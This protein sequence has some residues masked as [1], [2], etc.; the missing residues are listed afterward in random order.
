MKTIPIKTPK[1]KITILK[2]KLNT[3]PTEDCMV[4]KNEEKTNCEFFSYGQYFIVDRY[5][6]LAPEKF[7]HLAWRNIREDIKTVLGSDGRQ[8]SPTIVSKCSDWID[9]VFF[10][11]ER[12][13]QE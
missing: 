9:P 5:T 4:N 8:E 12:I 1:V 13:E 3:N 7:C 11:I 2:K 10:K 6:G